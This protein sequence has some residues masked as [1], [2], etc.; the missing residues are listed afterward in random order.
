MQKTASIFKFSALIFTFISWGY[1]HAQGLMG[2]SSQSAIRIPN[3]PLPPLNNTKLG[4]ISYY[5]ITQELLDSLRSRYRL[6]KTPYYKVKMSIGQFSQSGVIRQ[7]MSL[8]FGNQKRKD[9]VFLAKNNLIKGKLI[10]VDSNGVYLYQKS[11]KKLGF[12]PYSDIWIIRR[13]NT[14]EDKLIRDGVVGGVAGGIIGFVL[15]TDYD[16]I[17]TGFILAPILA[18]FG[19]GFTVS[20]T[21]IPEL[22]VHELQNTSRQ[23][24]NLK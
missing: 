11:A 8:K 14:L 2:T 18:V 19:A 21:A 24:L 10:A 22:L 1:S 6:Q 15:G 20:Q 17:G 9:K 23:K 7:Q 5:D 16:G 12:V 3:R 13:G 4:T